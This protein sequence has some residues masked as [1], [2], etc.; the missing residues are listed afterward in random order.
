M[1]EK[2]RGAWQNL[3]GG[4]LHFGSGRPVPGAWKRIAVP[5]GTCIL[6]RQEQ[7]RQ[8]AVRL[9]HEATLTDR[10]CF[11]TL[12]YDQAHLPPDG[13]LRY[14]DLVKFW[15][16]MRKQ[17]GGL[18]YFA[19]GEYGDQTLRP[20]YHA[21]LFGEDFLDGAIYTRTGTHP[22]WTN[23]AV[24][25]CWGLG[26][27]AIGSLT[28]ETARY[29]ASYVQKKLNAKQTYVRTDE[30]TGEL[31]P[32]EQPRAFMSRNLARDWWN[33]W[34]QGVIDHDYVVINAT[35]GKP[36]KAY[37]RWLSEQDEEKIIKIKEQRIARRNEQERGKNRTTLQHGMHARAL[38]A[39]ARTK[40]KSKSV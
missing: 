19:V 17:L 5:C 11:I 37:D 32:L 21:C 40:S 4:P 16:R 34:K 10:N 13:G 35:R 2:A 22:L 30:E 28:F 18:R 31:I 33:Q 6:C 1:C 9:T 39:H 27:V 20:H 24:Q 12:T 29:T 8:W 7:A 36:P 23:L 38:N 26:Q 25:R 14:A 3:D 15:K